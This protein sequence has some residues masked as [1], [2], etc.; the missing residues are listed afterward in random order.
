MERARK[1][2]NSRLR[3][4]MRAKKS[5]VSSRAEISLVRSASRTAEIV[6]GAA[7]L[8][9]LPLDSSLISR[10]PW[11]R[12]RRAWLRQGLG[13]G[14]RRQCRTKPACR[15]GALDDLHEARRRGL[16]PWA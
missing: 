7:V 15:R 8:I 3:F 4:S 10:S 9:K 6:H 2:F 5:L 11:E 14:R 13:R 12:G 1:A 16:G